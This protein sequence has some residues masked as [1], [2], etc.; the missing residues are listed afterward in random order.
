MLKGKQTRSNLFLY[1]WNVVNAIIVQ[2]TLLRTDDENITTVYGKN[3]DFVK[4]LHFTL[5]GVF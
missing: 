2:N 1:L 3:N 4:W 5:S